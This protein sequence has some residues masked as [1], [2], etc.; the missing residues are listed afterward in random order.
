M[1]FGCPDVL[2]FAY[3]AIRKG[4]FG[5]KAA[6]TNR[7]SNVS[8]GSFG[9]CGGTT[10]LASTTIFGGGEDALPSAAGSSRTAKDCRG[11]SAGEHL[12]AWRFEPA[13]RR[14]AD[15]RASDLLRRR[16]GRVVGAPYRARHPA[17]GGPR[18]YGRHGGNLRG[19]GDPQLCDPEALL[20]LDEANQ[21]AI[22]FLNGYGRLI[23]KPLINTMTPKTKPV[24]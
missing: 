4:A 3:R 13:M 9:R 17:R 19:A 20:E 5:G 11:A 7:I 23:E 21:R 14:S 1:R 24:T 12:P 16:N 8:S 22:L 10:F 15:G 6:A 2:R 18:I